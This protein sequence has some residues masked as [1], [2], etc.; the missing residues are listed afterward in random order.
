MLNR[1]GLEGKDET[2]TNELCRQRQSLLGESLDP[3]ELISICSGL[4]IG[5]SDI[6]HKESGLEMGNGLA[7]WGTLL[8]AHTTQ[9]KVE[10]R[11]EGEHRHGGVGLAALDEG[12]LALAKQ[13]DDVGDQRRGN[14]RN[15]C[16]HCCCCLVKE[17]SEERWGMSVGEEMYRGGSEGGVD[18][19][20]AKEK[21][22][23][24]RGIKGQEKDEAIDNEVKKGRME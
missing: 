1:R 21:V 13:C 20:S 12:P 18:D 10:D 11:C 7:T 15:L 4:D 3:F 16:R 8:G 14:G 5:I 9:P 2:M 24:G 19:T 22:G 23:F 17:S 6:E